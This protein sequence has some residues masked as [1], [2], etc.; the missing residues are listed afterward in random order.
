MW[1]IWLVDE[2]GLR[3]CSRFLQIPRKKEK[4]NRESAYCVTH[5]WESDDNYRC[6]LVCCSEEGE[7]RGSSSGAGGGCGVKRT[8]D[9]GHP[10]QPQGRVLGYERE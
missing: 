2:R 1:K 4:P 6:D 3:E 5:V 10:I 8:L 9:V 7:S